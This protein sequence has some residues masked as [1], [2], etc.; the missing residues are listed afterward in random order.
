MKKY[1]AVI[2]MSSVL[3]TGCSSKI[4]EGEIYKKDYQPEETIMIMTPMIHTNGKSSYTTYIPMFYHYPDRWCIWIKAIE[5][6]DEGK[7]DTAKYYTTEEVYEECDIGDMFSY[8]ED[9][10]YKEEPVEK[11]R[12]RN[13]KG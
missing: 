2:L 13:E 9:R 10:D 3:L 4:T 7:Y 11:K 1:I 12:I 5:K 6:N 8:E